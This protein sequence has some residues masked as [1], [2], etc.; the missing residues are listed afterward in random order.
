MGVFTSP[1]FPQTIPGNLECYWGFHPVYVPQRFRMVVAFEAVYLRDSEGA[2]NCTWVELVFESTVFFFFS[3]QLGSLL[4]SIAD[5]FRALSRFSGFP[6]RGGLSDDP[7]ARLRGKL[8]AYKKIESWAASHTQSMRSQ[9]A[10]FIFFRLI[11]F[12]KFAERLDG[13]CSH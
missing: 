4:A 7:K 5:V 12:Q 1:G 13:S 3:N 2:P 6:G 9:S 8:K 10:R 11:L